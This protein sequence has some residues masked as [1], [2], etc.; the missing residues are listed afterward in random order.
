MEDQKINNPSD[1]GFEEYKK[2][3]LFRLD[4][5][6]RH[7]E[8]ISMKIDLLIKDVLIL[9]VKAGVYGAIASVIIYIIINVI[10]KYLI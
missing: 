5:T 2:L 7:I 3:I 8:D 1:N 9:K 10:V 4:Q 6:D